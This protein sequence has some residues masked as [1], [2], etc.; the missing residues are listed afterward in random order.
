MTETNYYILLE[1]D[2]SVKDVQAVVDVANKRISA[3]NKDVNHPRKGAKAKET[4]KAIKE[5]I[6]KIR[7][8]PELLEIHAK[9]YIK[10]KAKEKQ[11]HE[12]AL[13]EVAS[14]LVIDNEIEEVSLNAL[15]NQYKT[16]LGD[17]NLNSVQKQFTL[18]YG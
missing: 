2:P 8:K 12:K 5:L 9:E 4:V 14:M 3:W 17:R 11:E 13:R 1:I 16:S 10:E 6:A 7:E 18:H 15:V